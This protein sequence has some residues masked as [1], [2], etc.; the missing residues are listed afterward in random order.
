[1]VKIFLDKLNRYNAKEIQVVDPQVM[2]AFRKYSWPGNIRE[3]EN[4]IERAYI[5]EK[6]M[7]LSPENFPAELFECDTMVQIPPL[8]GDVTLDTYRRKAL[9]NIEIMYLKQVLAN[10]KGKINE[11]AAYAGLSTR[12]LHKLMKK[13]GLRK[14][15]FKSPP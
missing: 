6:S 11:S 15:D 14:E 5:L 2:D 8:E 10:H 7:T 4:L 3:L 9:K 12:Q 1:M 13:Y